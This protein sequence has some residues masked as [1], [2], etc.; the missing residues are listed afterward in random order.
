[1]E[2]LLLVTHRRHVKVW[3]WKVGDLGK[4]CIPS[5]MQIPIKNWREKRKVS[6]A[7]FKRRAT[8]V[9]NSIDQIKFDFSTVVARRLKPSR[10]TAV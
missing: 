1:M 5:Y 6:K 10:A 2:S 9:S 3:S 4:I 7:R 8:A